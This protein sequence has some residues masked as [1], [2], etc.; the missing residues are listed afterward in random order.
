MLLNILLALTFIFITL[1][2]YLCCSRQGKKF[3]LSIAIR[4]LILVLFLF[5]IFE[6]HQQQ[7]HFILILTAWVIFEVIES[8]YKKKKRT[9]ST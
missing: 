5:V 1:H 7:I 9:S 8:L 2:A 6:Q 3:T 4:L